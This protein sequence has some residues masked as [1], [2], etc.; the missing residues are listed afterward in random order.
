MKPA[1]ALARLLPLIVG[2]EAIAF[3]IAAVLHLGVPLPVGFDEPVI[4][5]AAI[6]EG[7]IGIFLAI[8]ALALLAS[9]RL[10]W[11]LAVAAH[12]FGI[13][14]VLVGTFALAVGA[15]PSTEANTI[16]H[17]VALAVLVA[18]LVLLLTE[19]GRRA[20]GREPRARS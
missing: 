12:V 10:A 8:A 2:I 15:G 11:P 3:M 4:I 9:D 17:R 6:A 13:T 19:R 1:G 14:G 20:A 18:V 7:L 5:P 16:Y